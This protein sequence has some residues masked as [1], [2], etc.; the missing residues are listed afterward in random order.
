MKIAI[1]SLLVLGIHHAMALSFPKAEMNTEELANRMLAIKEA[2]AGLEKTL[3][4]YVEDSTD[5]E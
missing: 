1:F 5:R 2:S 4:Y 3:S